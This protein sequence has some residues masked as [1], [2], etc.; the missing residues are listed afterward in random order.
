MFRFKLTDKRKEYLARLE[1]DDSFAVLKHLPRT[2]TFYDLTPELNRYLDQQKV[3]IRGEVTRKTRLVTTPK[4]V[5][6]FNFYIIYNEEEYKV[7]TYNRPY[8]AKSIGVGSEVMISGK[9]NHYKKEIILIDVVNKEVRNTSIKPIYHLCEGV[10]GHDFQKVVSLAYNDLLEHNELKEIIPS[11]LKEKYQL[12]SRKEAYYDAHFPTIKEKLRQAFRYLKYEELLVYSLK[13]QMLKNENRTSL[14]SAIKKVD[15]YFVASLLKQNNF[16]LTNDQ[17]VVIR[18]IIE[19]LKKDGLM[20]RMLQGDVGTGKT[21]VAALALAANFSSSYQGVLMAPTDILARQHYEFLKKFYECSDI[22]VELLVSSLPNKQKKEI[23][24]K[25]KDGSIDVVVGT[26]ALIQKNVEYKKL[27]LAIIDEQHRFGVNQ[28]KSLKEKGEHVETLM[29]TATP[30]PRTLAITLYGDMDIS[31]LKEFPNK[32]RDITTKVVYEQDLDKIK[33]Y[34]CEKTKEGEKTFVVCPLIVNDDE[35]RNSVEEVYE[36]FVSYFENKVKVGILHGKMSSEEKENIMMEFKNSDTDILVA[37]TVVE[38]GID[39]KNAS[40]MVIFDAQSFG[41]ATLHQLRG[42]I[43]RG[44]QKGNC[45]LVCTTSEKLARQRLQY[46]EDNEDGFEIARYDL[47]SRGPGDIGGVRQSG[48]PD[49][50]VSDIYSDI[51]I[52]E[53]ARIDAQNILNNPEDINNKE[54]IAYISSNIS[55][56]LVK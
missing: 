52:L 40:T 15:E 6:V 51:R 50:N 2:Y 23:I 44:G 14:T 12:V 9:Y 54:I 11:Y 53:V 24:E 7:V 21:L 28:R 32:K 3:V 29:M 45:F 22:K 46:L 39:V 34:I 41:L 17:K 8:L 4:R 13:L 10:K 38:V 55:D 35:E 31:I 47:A 37:T 43:G 20:Y 36:D 19:D 18:E 27:G 42:R 49:L 25:I 56:N 1:L 33:K 26:H 5:Q 48:V 30:I 16:T